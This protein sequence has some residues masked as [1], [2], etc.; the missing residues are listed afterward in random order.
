M[1]GYLDLAGKHSR[2]DELA[3]WCIKAVENGELENYDFK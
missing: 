3:L 2:V 1:I